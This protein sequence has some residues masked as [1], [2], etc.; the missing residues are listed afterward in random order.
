MLAG[1]SFGL[2][3]FGSLLYWIRLFG[4]PA[5]IALVLL[6]TSFVIVAMA[7]TGLV[8][9]SLPKQVRLLAF[10]VAFLLAE[11]A[12]SHFPFGGFGWGGLGYTQHAYPWMLRT[13]S[14]A[15]V[16]G[17]A[18]ALLLCNES[19][20][21]IS[22]KSQR[23]Q[24]HFR[25]LVI[26]T[27]AL[28][29]PILVPVPDLEGTTSNIAMIQGNAPEGLY[30]PG[31]DDFE[32]VENHVRL[33]STL[34]PGDVD[35]VVWPESSVDRDPFVN[36][37]I[38]Q[39]V[40]GAV[41]RSRT[42]FLIGANLEADND[43]RRALQ[44]A[45][46]FYRSDGSLV[47]KYVKRQPVP[48]GER[49]YFRRFLEPLI[50]E[51]DRVPY[52]FVSGAEATVFDLPKG[53]FSSVICYEST[54]PSL[55]RD[56]VQQG[57]RLLIV[58]TN[59]SSFERTAASRQH[60]AFSQV[61]AAEH[62]IYVAH[63]ALTGI[64]AVVEP[65]GRISQQ[66]RLFE[67]AVLTPTV[68]F[69]TGMTFYG[70]VGDWL[71]LSLAVLV[72]VL[73]IWRASEKPRTKRRR[74]GNVDVSAQPKGEVLVV[75]PTYN[76][77]TNI[78]PLLDQVLVSLPRCV[79]LVVDDGSP[80]GTGDVVRAYG[81]KDV[82]VQI[83]QRDAKSGLGRAYLAG[84]RWGLERD[85]EHFIEMDAD[86]S[87]YPTDLPRLYSAG[88]KAALVIGS[89]YVQGG[90][91]QGWSRGRHLL[92][93]AGN[94]YSRT[95]LGFRIMDSTSGFRCFRREVLESIDLD[96]VRSDGYG[97][98]IDMAYRTVRMGFEVVEIPIYFRERTTG[99]SKMSRAIVVEAIASVTFWALRD[100]FKGTRSK[101][102]VRS[103]R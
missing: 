16:W 66:T 98:Q 32:V 94:L 56:F 14:W 64:S 53:R 68:R 6:E 59:N 24:W 89:R 2:V 11:Y 21:R 44:N 101:G 27:L 40:V 91:V 7:A 74:V 17:I 34:R 43:G 73:A 52:D 37:D 33:S 100:L 75:V 79:V 54:Y 36:G 70:K 5:Y 96:S 65:S 71:P 57:A 38:E 81:S 42:P 48:F 9:Q 45:S 86:H 90:G 10:P 99:R 15:G 28:V 83:L 67:E 26:A 84:F 3:F 47:G 29:L 25:Y 13:A 18:F 103:H 92:S 85:F 77:V 63:A 1:S 76:E 102:K 61:R 22:R 12:R 49:V 19:L 31:S 78:V 55:V 51:L 8:R 87:H 72:L 23:R 69:A 39:A 60:V 41:K 62:R 97:F 20:S 58:S 35:L 30:D 80:D 4:L 46:L 50:K 95:M 82:R 93:R 88:Q